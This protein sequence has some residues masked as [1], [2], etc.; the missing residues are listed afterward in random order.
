MWGVQ[1]EGGATQERGLNN[2]GKIGRRNN[3]GRRQMGRGG[4]RGGCLIKKVCCSQ[5]DDYVTLSYNSA[6]GVEG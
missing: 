3:T 1:K 2:E 5:E 4:V 6:R